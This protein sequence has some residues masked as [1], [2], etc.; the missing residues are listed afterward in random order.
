MLP[1]A[2]YHRQEISKMKNVKSTISA[3]AITAASAI[4]AAA[5]ALSACGDDDP[6]GY[7]INNVTG[8]KQLAIQGFTDP[9][10]LGCGVEVSP[11]TQESPQFPLECVSWRRSGTS[12]ELSMTNIHKGCDGGGHSASAHIVNDD[13]IVWVVGS[14]EI[15]KCGW[16]AYDFSMTI[17]GA[18]PATRVELRVADE[19]DSVHHEVSNAIDT[20][21]DSGMLC[22]YSIHGIGLER[23]DGTARQACIPDVV[24]ESVCEVGLVCKSGLRGYESTHSGSYCL[25][26]CESDAECR[27]V[28]SCIEGLCLITSEW[29]D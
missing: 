15:L 24:E 7:G 1:S 10:I 3:T 11:A 17:L 25:P 9:K 12:M 21:A 19:A 4:I 20:T 29:L 23:T 8:S 5:T 13:M 26:R 22:R 2:Y 28:E 14:G 6:L 18:A 16:C 27:V